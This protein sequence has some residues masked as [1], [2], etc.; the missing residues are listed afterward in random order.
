MNTREFSIKQIS[1]E[2]MNQLHNRVE[3]LDKEE[4]MDVKKDVQ[5][6]FTCWTHWKDKRPQFKYYEYKS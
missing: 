4:K 2:R 1:H 6:K 3:E 5:D